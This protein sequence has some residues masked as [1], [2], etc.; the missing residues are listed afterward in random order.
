MIT[1]VEQM[2]HTIAIANLKGGTGK[3]N[4]SY[5]LAGSLVEQGH[6]VLIIDMD[7]Q[8]SL[9]S[10]IFDDYLSLKP[11]VFTLLDDEFDLDPR[12]VIRHTEIDNLDVLPAGRKLQRLDAIFGTESDAP[13]LLQ[14]AIASIQ[15]NYDF[16]II[17]CPPS[18]G[19]ATQMAMVAADS[20]I[21]PT[22]CGF[23]SIN[24]TARTIE[25]MQAMKKFN[26]NLALLGVLINR[27]D[28]R[29]GQ[30][31]EFRNLLHE[32]YQKLMFGTELRNNVQY[33]EVP[34]QRLPVTHLY[35]RS[36]QADAYRALI[37]E[38]QKRVN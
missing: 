19:L 8:A 11:T 27:Y 26:P 3:T 2:T 12:E 33:A 23:Q 38:L 30:E 6:S 24:E 4:V 25:F 16:I 18:L 13:A 29:R 20:L 1:L 37:K 5:N 21:V 31:Q 10:I 36:Q 22:E 32:R 15:G 17:D 35:P 14:M 34:T 28:M 7:G 9:T